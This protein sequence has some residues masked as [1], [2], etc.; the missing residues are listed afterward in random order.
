MLD[1]EDAEMDKAKSLLVEA[2]GPVD[3]KEST[4]AKDMSQDLVWGEGGWKEE[5]ERKFI[6]SPYHVT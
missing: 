1:N 5:R 2:Y 6:S 4:K 3:R